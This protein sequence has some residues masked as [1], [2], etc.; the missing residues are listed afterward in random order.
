[1]TNKN[2]QNPFR[3]IPGGLSEKH[4]D[5]YKEFVSAHITDTRLMGVVGMTIHWKLPKN[6]RF[7]DFYQFYYFDA[8][9]NGFDT[10]KSLLCSGEPHE[11][12][13]LTKLENS[14][15]GGLGAH[16]IQIS[17]REAVYMVQ[18]Y[19]ELTLKSNLPLPGNRDEYEFLLTPRVELT[20]K[21]SFILMC[22]QCPIIDSPYQVINYFLMR[23]FGKDFGAAKFLTK[24]YVRTNLFP[25]HKGATLLRNVIEEAPDEISGSNTRYHSTDDDKDFGTFDTLKSYMC[26]S[27]IEYSGKYFLLVTQVTLDQ[28]RVVKYEKISSFRVTTQEASLMTSR[29]EFVTV[30]DL[31]P[32]APPFDISAT[33]LTRKAMTT[34]YDNGTLFM[35]F[36]P[37][38]DHVKKKT[39]ILNDD[40]LG[41]YFLV[42]NSQL[43]LA[44][45]SLENIQAMEDD[46]AHSYM[47]PF[48]VP[49]S[50]YEFRDPVLYDFMNSIFEDFE[51]FVETI[52]MPPK[53]EE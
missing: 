53:D 11:I 42:D 52:S 5:S 38:N 26:E 31:I 36:Q 1:M 41:V 46:L 9:E 2:I 51:D 40:V 49:V 12:E 21:E 25:E 37:D 30:T 24:G 22:K 43:I 34:E 10:Y 33:K 6:T 16:K 19:V 50:K 17:E 23:C 28:L 4:S 44:A 14:I 47:A 20:E 32:S 29:T 48:V 18:S 45:Y 39:Y 3:V 35:V 27:L 15:I 8:E 7:R 13:E